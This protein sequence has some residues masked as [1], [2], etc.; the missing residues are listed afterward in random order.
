MW[1]RE[2]VRLGAL[3]GGQASGARTVAQAGVDR[4]VV[5]WKVGGQ[6]DL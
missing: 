2:G 3:A 4:C 5:Q 1:A 6:V